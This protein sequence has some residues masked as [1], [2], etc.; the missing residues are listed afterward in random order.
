MTEPKDIY[1]EAAKWLARAKK[2]YQHTGQMSDWQV[3]ISNLRT[4][5]ARRPALQRE[6]AGL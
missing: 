6:L 5:Y 3:Y 1:P 2:A 4:T